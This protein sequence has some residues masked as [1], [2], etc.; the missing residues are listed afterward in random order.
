MLE[1]DVCVR[2][3]NIVFGKLFKAANNIFLRGFL[4]RSTGDQLYACGG[5]LFVIIDEVGGSFHADNIA[6]FE[7]S[8]S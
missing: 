2:K 4:S 7:E 5:E 1:V 6:S 8:L 3:R